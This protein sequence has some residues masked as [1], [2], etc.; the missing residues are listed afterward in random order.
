MTD[1][2]ILTISDVCSNVTKSYDLKKRKEVIF[3][4]TGD[5]LDNKF[6]KTD[7][8][9]INKLP[10]QAKKSIKKNDILFS[11]IRPKNK[12]YIFI[13]RDLDDYV[14]STKFMV[15]RAKKNILPK[16]LFYFL[17]S[18]KNLRNFQMEAE[19]R[20]GTFPQIT[21]DS[22]E[23]LPIDVPSLEKQKRISDILDTIENKISLYDQQISLYDNLIRIIFQSWFIKFEPIKNRLNKNL[24][25]LSKE[26][27]IIFPSSFE[28][29]EQGSV[30]KNWK[31]KKISDYF[32]V[33]KGLSY[34]GKFLTENGKPMI[35]LGCFGEDGFFK[36]EKIKNYSGDFKKQNILSEGDIALANSDMTQNRITLGSPIQV[37]EIDGNKDFIFTHHVYGLFNKDDDKRLNYFIYNL[38]L[39]TRFRKVVGGGATGTTVLSLPEDIIEDFSFFLPEDKI[40]NFFNQIAN[41][42]YEK[43][44][45]LKNE[46]KT[47]IELR[48]ILLSEFISGKVKI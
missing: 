40:L 48:D 33:K 8:Y 20:S 6:L 16:Y 15:I 5:V 47:T 1:E 45:I 39:Q 11:E 9:S 46:K 13:D 41:K 12:R 18:K 26:L 3:I 42:I 22:I 10:G 17:K 25:T 4:N 30:P 37:C 44:K 21:F 43:I 32:E 24:S 2:N 27:D 29:T 28:E 34:K 35:N 23:Y 38:L 7:T 36:I 14:V 19:S 31:L